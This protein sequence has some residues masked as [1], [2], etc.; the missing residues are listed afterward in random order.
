M[1]HPPL[2]AYSYAYQPIVDVQRQEVV[3]FEALVRGSKNESAYSV[4][5]AVGDQMDRFNNESRTRAIELAA[6]LQL[7][8]HLSLNMMPNSL[9]DPNHSPLNEA[10]ADAVLAGLNPGQLV[11]EITEGAII[12][13][14]ELFKHS[15][16][17][18]RGVGVKFAIDDF[19]AGYSGLN[20]LAEFQ[21]DIL[22]IDMA[23]IRDIQ[24]RGPKQAIIR[25]I[26]CTCKD[27][28]IDILAEGVETLD[29]YEW[30]YNEGIVLYQGYLFARPGF[31][32]LPGAHF[33]TLV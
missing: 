2:P 14:Y 26:I 9:S 15:A 24:K 3:A 19:G 27:L 20:M 17:Q 21:P 29:E 12:Q 1:T 23:L 22:K 5:Q 28:G 30:L 13:N 18:C 25:G 7:T 4:L 33:P 32:C 8:C 6:K 16:A 10:V 31:E 11:L